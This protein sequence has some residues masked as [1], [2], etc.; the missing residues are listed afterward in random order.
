MRISLMWIWVS[1]EGNKV[2][3]H[4][5]IFMNQFPDEDNN[6]CRYT[7]RMKALRNYGIMD[8]FPL[9]QPTVFAG[10]HNVGYRTKT[11]AMDIAKFFCL[12]KK[13]GISIAKKCWILS[14]L[15]IFTDKKSGEFHRY[16][17]IEWEVD[18]YMCLYVRGSGSGGCMC[19]CHSHSKINHSLFPL[20]SGMFLHAEPFL[21]PCSRKWK[22]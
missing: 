22:K 19:A 1:S 16:S 12:S 2:V 18:V 9:V 6:G 14:I 11:G 7:E 17:S 15:L 5:A 3:H 21:Q 4:D 10:G 20:L 13:N 8:V